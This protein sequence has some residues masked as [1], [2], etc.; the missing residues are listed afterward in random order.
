MEINI[1]H[2]DEKPENYQIINETR[3]SSQYLGHSFNIFVCFIN[4]SSSNNCMIVHDYNWKELNW[5]EIFIYCETIFY[6]L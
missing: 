4:T 3:N 2:S 6:K 5:I 1:I